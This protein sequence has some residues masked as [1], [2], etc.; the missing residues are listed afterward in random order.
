MGKAYWGQEQKVEFERSQSY[1]AIAF[2]M[3]GSS[4]FK[5]FNLGSDI[6]N[7]A[8]RGAPLNFP[9]EVTS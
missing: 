9:F 4:Q 8:K 2:Y 3:Q 7:M 1:Q 5:S 6:R